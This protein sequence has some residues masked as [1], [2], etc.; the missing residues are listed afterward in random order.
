MF[1][2]L[3][4]YKEKITSIEY[5][6]EN[7][8]CPYCEKKVI[9]KKGNINAWHFAHLK[10]ECDYFEYKGLSDWHLNWQNLWQKE[11]REVRIIKEDKLHIADV[12]SK[13]GVVIEFQNSPIKDYQ[14]SLRSGFYDKL[15]WVLN[16]TEYE[17]NE[18]NLTEDYL[19]IKINNCNKYLSNLKF[20]AKTNYNNYTKEDWKKHNDS[21]KVIQVLTDNL[22]VEIYSSQFDKKTEYR[23]YV[24]KFK[25]FFYESIEHYVFLDTGLNFL[26]FITDYQDFCTNKTLTV[27]KVLKT[28][29]L[30]KYL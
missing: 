22:T 13:S 8:F 2:A 30:K 5:N 9:H 4:E 10:K 26:Y 19:R 7:V 16:F 29:F 24:N 28:D 1:T 27:K 15:V 12:I 25:N 3:N 11:Q 17:F 23:I 14:I 20:K 18:H 6:G 21:K